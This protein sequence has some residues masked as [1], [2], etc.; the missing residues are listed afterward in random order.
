VTASGEGGAVMTPGSRWEFE[1]IGT[2]WQLDTVAELS[3]TVR[4]EVSAEID[5][6]DR[7]WSRFRPDAAIAPLAAAAGS[8]PNPVDAAEMLGLYVELSDATAHAVNPLIGDALSRRGY[9]A[10]YGF[11]DRGAR[12]AP[13]GWPQLLTWDDGLLTLREPAV[14]DVGALGKGR[15]VD[16]VLRLVA[17]RVDGPV[18]VDGGG[19]IALR[20]TESI[21]LEHP[22]DATRAVGVWRITDAALCASA[23][24]RRAWA[25][26]RADCTT[27]STPARASRCVPSPR[28]GR[29]PRT[30]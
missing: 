5:A 18:T 11:V 28:P 3:A 20:G 25:G 30:R 23:T 29:W 14:I 8:I 10:G 2:R 1:A 16:R 24:Q 7:A 27:C 19:D 17:G 4:A 6:F 22:F 15:L 26:A 21:A 13:P 12:P 9:D